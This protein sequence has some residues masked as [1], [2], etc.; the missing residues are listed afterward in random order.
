MGPLEGG[1]QRVDTGK[2]QLASPLCRGLKSWGEGGRWDPIR[3]LLQLSRP[4]RVVCTWA[5]IV[6]V[7][8]NGFWIFYSDLC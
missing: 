7:R 2:C 6:V 8:R 3:K 1:R 5:G 4:K